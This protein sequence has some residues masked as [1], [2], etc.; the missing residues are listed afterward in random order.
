MTTWPLTLTGEI[1]VDGVWTP[2]KMRQDPRITIT[3]GMTAEG[4]AIQP[5]RCEVTLD[6]TDRAYSLRNPG[7][8]LW[9]KIGR[10]TPFRLRVGDLPAAPAAVLTDTFARTVASGWG[11][12]SSGTAW[13]V[14]DPNADAP[15]ASDY[16]VTT[17]LGNLRLDTVGESRYIRTSGLD[18]ADFDAT[19]TVQT[20]ALPVGTDIDSGL[21]VSLAVR[22]DE[23]VHNFYLIDI[24]LLINGGLPAGQGLRVSLQALRADAAAGSVITPPQ[25]VP[26]L[27]YALNTPLR[28]RVRCAGPEIRARVWAN[29]QAEPDVWHL[30]VYDDT[31]TSGEL[32]FR[33]RVR[34]SGT[35]LPVTVSVGDV[36]VVPLTADTGV[37]RIAGEISSWS[38]KRDESGNN[39]TVPVVPAGILRRYENGRA[40]LKSALRRR[41]A[42]QGALAYWSFEEGRQGD[43]YIAEFGA[44]STAGP[45]TVTGLDFAKDSDLIGSAPLPTVA[46]SASL[47]SKTIPGENTGAWSVRMM[48]HLTTDGFPTDAGEHQILR[49]HVADAVA[50]SAEIVVQRSGSDHLIRLRVRDDS[51][52]SLGTVAFTHEAA[53][54][55]GGPGLLDSWRLVLVTAVQTATTTVYTLGLVYPNATSASAATSAIT[56]TAGHP[57]RITTDFGTGVKGMGIGHL[58][59]WGVSATD[60]YVLPHNSQAFAAEL[61]MRGLSVRDFMRTLSVDQGSALEIHGPGTTVL[62]PQDTRTYMELIEAAAVTD[63]G[64]LTEQRSS[65]G[66]KYQTRE[67]RYNQPVDLTL[68]FTQGLIAE[69]FDP[70]D[71]DKDAKNKI[72]AKR[73]EGSEATAVL[74]SGRLSVQP[75]PDGIGEVED[76]ADTIV[77]ADTQLPDQAAWRLHLATVDEM[78]VAQLTLKMGN[79]RLHALIDQVLLLDT[80]SRIQITNTPHEYGP[81]GFDLIVTGYRETFATGLWEI[82]FNCVPASPWIVGVRDTDRRDTSGSQLAAAATTGATVL[83]V[84]TTR[85]PHWTT[86]VGSGFDILAGGERMTVSAVTS[87]LRDTFTRTVAGSWGSPDTGPAWNTVGGG[88]AS[89][90]SVGSGFGVQ[91]LST[92]DTSRRTA[93]TAAHADFDLYC[94]ITASAAA[95]GDSLYGAA[96]ARMLDANNMYMART[97]FTT[98]GAAILT[99]RKMVAGVQTQIGASYT[100]PSGY[101]PGT[102][103]RV[104]FQGQ[105]ST[106]QAK[107]WLASDAEPDRW[108]IRGTDTAITAANQIGTRSIRVTGNT[109]AATVAIRYD[110]FDVVNPQKFT[111]T[112]S[113]NGVVKAHPAATAVSLARPAVRAL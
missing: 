7:S 70:T 90:Y 6:N 54:G 109:N 53:L 99:V 1:L 21:T 42:Q 27:T 4:S 28:V 23:T 113:V 51:G 37:I 85:G 44:Q 49:F 61:G 59:L 87:F 3:R 98:G 12:S 40:P 38:P 2:V 83:D 105:G 88:P 41:L 17:G 48:A 78:R 18:L 45:L 67:T 72:T 77:N 29:G 106:F 16:S 19:F 71:D 56:T 11:T 80:G 94:D 89:D 103:V 60:G 58:S 32:A 39:R 79:P 63:M 36:D 14:Y 69:P 52:T 8:T 47:R 46:A 31:H 22:V 13:V 101:A 108:N 30:Q 25:Q 100:L 111:A 68:D 10:N 91:V 97:E 104:R 110:N 43:R 107:M 112:R 73:R 33:G 84:V 82:T 15:P 57:D 34:A 62:G 35:P 95:T 24:N 26:G 65:P 66:L 55:L 102:F 76:S 74:A 92:L 20:A 64:L 86:S 50:A 96:T 81:D 9:G 5:G 93:V 75:P